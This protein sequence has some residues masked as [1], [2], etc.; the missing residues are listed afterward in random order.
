LKTFFKKQIDQKSLYI[1]EN[2]RRVF[3][4]KKRDVSVKALPP[5][6]KD[7]NIIK[8]DVS[9]NDEKRKEKTIKS[10]GEKLDKD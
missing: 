8:V 10:L 9:G 2:I 5:S 4:S 3:A 7:P 1:A 6:E